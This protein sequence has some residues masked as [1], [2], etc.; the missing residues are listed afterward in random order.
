MNLVHI[1]LAQE[2]KEDNKKEQVAEDVIVRP[3][4]EYKGEG[5]RDPFQPIAPKMEKI[6]PGK[7]AIAAEPNVDLKNFSVSGIVWGGRFPQAII[8]GKVLGIGDKIDGIEILGI[9]KSG[10]TVRSGGVTALLTVS[11]KTSDPRKE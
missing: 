7:E 11:A 4:V 10:V 9:D 2:S 8:N 1:V 3:V 6:I 5:L